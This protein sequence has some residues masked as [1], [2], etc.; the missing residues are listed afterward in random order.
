MY[1][2]ALVWMVLSCWAPCLVLG[3]D[4]ICDNFVRD[5]RGNPPDL[6]LL[7]PDAMSPVR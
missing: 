7:F 3:T 6:D 1:L 2:L 5:I 4:C